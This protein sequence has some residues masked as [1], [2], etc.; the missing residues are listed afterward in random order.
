M[1][2]LKVSPATTGAI[3]RFI[4]SQ[5]VEEGKSELTARNY[6]MWLKPYLAWLDGRDALSVSHEDVVAYVAA[7]QSGYPNPH[8]RFSRVK[9]IKVFYKWA[10]RKAL[11]ASD[12]AAGIRTPRTP[13]QVPRV[14][15]YDVVEALRRA[16]GAG[17]FTGKRDR[18]LL[19]VAFDCGLRSVELRRLRLTDIDWRERTL[20]VEGKAAD[21]EVPPVRQVPFA[22]V[23]TRTLRKYI[24]ARQ[25]LPGDVL[26]VD[27][28]GL[29]LTRRSFARV[30]ERLRARAGI[31]GVRVSW[32]S[33]RHAF[34]T[35]MLRSGCDEEHLRRMAGWRDR[36]M[37]QRYAHLVTAD[38]RRAHDR[39]SPAD[40]LL[41]GE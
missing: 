20:R 9:A 26:F 19:E 15:G 36:Q 5:K 3:E 28:Q 7:V 8:T 23:V 31:T 10:A 18:A 21:G 30:I 41:R 22:T 32:H 37:L 1:A 34:V 4:I 29:P 27:R 13:M 24:D 39:H 14:V 11:V 38:L 35:E 2:P 25:M 12:P 6:R 17:T 40:R 16:C 33:L